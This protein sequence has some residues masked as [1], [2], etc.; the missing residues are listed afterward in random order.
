[1][2]T[3]EEKSFVGLK[4][5]KKEKYERWAAFWVLKRLGVLVVLLLKGKEIVVIP[6]ID[7]LYD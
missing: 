5:E 7:H 3:H 4:R 2:V 1:M 6:T